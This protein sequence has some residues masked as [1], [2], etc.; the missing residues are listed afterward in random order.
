MSAP[1]ISAQSAIS[2]FRRDVKLSVLLK[3]ALLVCAVASFMGPAIGLKIDASL[4]LLVIGGVWVFLSM[5]S[6][7]GSR[8]AAGSPLLIAAGRWDAAEEQIDGALRAFSLSKKVKVLSLHHL[9]VLRHAQRR[10]QESAMLCRAL[11]N[12]RSGSARGLVR[13]TRLILAD[14]L[15]ELNDLSGAH[16][17]LSRLHGDPMS[18]VESLQLML[19]Q[20]DYES[21]IGAWSHMMGGVAGKVQMAELMSGEAAARA[22]AF[23]AL[24]AQ[25]LGQTDWAVW[26]RRRVELLTDVKGLCVN[27]P[28]LTELWP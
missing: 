5:R 24:A 7:H 14:S 20:L 10:W 18:L 28:L 3:A 26:L 21:R 19:V 15:L 4:V 22:Q 8:L 12:Q 27:R 2:R 6:V 11:L 23:L 9:A 16:E 25:K 13:A 1:L 17:S